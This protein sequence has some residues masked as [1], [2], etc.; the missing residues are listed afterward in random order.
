MSWRIRAGALSAVVLLA[1]PAAAAPVVI[2][3]ATPDRRPPGA[4]RITVFD[5]DAAWY[6]RALHGIAPP[7][8]RSLGFLDD[9][10]AWY[11]PFDHPGMM[12]RYDLRGWHDRDDLRPRRLPE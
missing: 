9:Q 4:P 6:R 11:F 7:Y 8:P 3:G 5:K 1:A 12:G 2:G 10:G